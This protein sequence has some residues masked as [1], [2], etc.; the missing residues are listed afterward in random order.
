VRDAGPAAHAAADNA[1]AAERRAVDPATLPEAQRP[2]T[3]TVVLNV[4]SVLQRTSTRAFG[5]CVHGGINPNPPPGLRV[6]WGQVEA[7][8]DPCVA[9]VDQAAVRFDEGPLDR[10]PVK[11][12]D[13]AVLTYGEGPAEG[14]I[15]PPGTGGTCWRSG[16]GAPE[17]KPNGCV[18]ALGVP[19]VDWVRAAP[20]GL[21]PHIA[22]PHA[23]RNNPREWDVSTPYRRQYTRS[24]PLGASPPPPFGFLLSAGSPSTG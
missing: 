17:P 11:T 2:G 21:V 12:I 10:L 6:G 4:S 15:H 23:V 7:D 22:A 9:D 5:D 8:G 3:H 14:C 13:R 24:A 20:R 19:T 1:K 16:S 18:A